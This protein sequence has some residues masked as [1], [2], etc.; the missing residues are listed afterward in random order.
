MTSTSSHGPRA[1]AGLTST[2]RRAVLVSWER[3][4]WGS[5]CLSPELFWTV[6]HWALAVTHAAPHSRSHPGPTGCGQWPVS[7]HGMWQTVGAE[8]ES[9][10]HAWL[11]L[12]HQNAWCPEEHGMSAWGVTCHSQW[13]VTPRARESFW[14]SYFDLWTFVLEFWNG[15][16]GQIFGVLSFTTS[17]NWDPER[18]ANLPKTIQQVMKVPHVELSSH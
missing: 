9:M 5:H 10:S 7:R 12:Q 16:G 8:S 3:R 17:G 4:V 18:L 15:R 1:G 2:K 6:N 13:T 14:G 11:L